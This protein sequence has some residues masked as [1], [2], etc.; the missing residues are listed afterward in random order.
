[1]RVAVFAKAPVAG[2]VKTRLAPLLGEEGA[3]KLHTQLV[4]RAIATAV[5]SAVG[6]V[7]LWCAPD[8]S[9]PFFEGCAARYGVRL[10]AQA[11]AD[12]GAR[13]NHA[14]ETSHAEGQSLVLI[15]CDCPSLE[16]ATVRAAAKALA[17]N[18]A[19]FVPAEDGGYVLVG[20]ARPMPRIFEAIGWGSPAVMMQTRARLAVAGTRWE[21]LATHWD[22][23]RPEDYARAQRQ[24][25]VAGAGA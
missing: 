13:M 10:R 22:I 23:D 24:G 14:F 17:T 11:G 21:E 6:D 1:M 16:A 5:E 25:L 2:R 8:E 7:E 20:L 15:G 3:A 4:H 9:H 12:L 18:E 19:V